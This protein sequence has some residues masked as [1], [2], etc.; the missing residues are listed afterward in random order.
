MALLIAYP[1]RLLCGLGRIFMGKH[2]KFIH[3]RV[4]LELSLPL[5]WCI[6]NRAGRTIRSLRSQAIPLLWAAVVR[7]EGSGYGVTKG[8]CRKFCD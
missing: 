1:I 4:L 8:Y 6:R 7:V 5:K 2:I 3:C